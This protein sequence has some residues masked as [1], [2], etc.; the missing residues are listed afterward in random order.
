MINIFILKFPHTLLAEEE[1]LIINELEKLL[2]TNPTV[3]LNCD[4]ESADAIIFQEKFSFKEFRY[5]KQ[6]KK[7]EIIA[8]HINKIYTIN[9]DDCATGLLKGLYTS[10]P[11]RR[12]NPAF[13]VAI[14]YDSYPNEMVLKN[15]LGGVPIKYLAGWRGNPLTNSLRPKL[16][17]TFKDDP[18]VLVESTSF[19]WADKRVDEES[20]KS[21]YVRL[22]KSSKFSLCP[23]GWAPVSFRIYESM[24]LGRCPVI[25]ADEF[26]APEGPNWDEFAIFHPEKKIK[27]LKKVLEYRSSNYQT[28][29]NSA[30]QNWVTFF[31]PTKVYNYYIVKLLELIE[32]QK[33]M[34]IKSQIDFGSMQSYHTYYTNGWLLHQRIIRKIHRIIEKMY[35]K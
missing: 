19:S 17:N 8:K 4:V 11:A 13:H 31:S 14:P 12:F 20:D 32:K 21:L 30:Y 33:S 27:T 6:L 25:I 16:I 22:I 3:N 24:A 34:D 26:V 23:R 2:K 35:K 15:E 28:L 5:I 7:D 9:V 18:D 10:L 29:G 1:G